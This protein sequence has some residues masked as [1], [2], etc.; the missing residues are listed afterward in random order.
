MATSNLLA[1][2]S[3]AYIEAYL[4]ATVIYE[5]LSF[6]FNCIFRVIE[7]RA[8]R[9]LNLIAPDASTQTA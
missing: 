7:G 6:V 9:Y 8:S 4:M 5:V 2:S 1:T 3:Y